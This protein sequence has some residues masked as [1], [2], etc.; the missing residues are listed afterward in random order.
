MVK[1]FLSGLLALLLVLAVFPMPEALALETSGVMVSNLEELKATQGTAAAVT[2]KTGANI[3]DTERTNYSFASLTIQEGASLNVESVYCT[4]NIFVYGT[5][6]TVRDIRCYGDFV[7]ANTGSLVIGRTL[8]MDNMNTSVCTLSGSVE[9]LHTDGFG[10]VDLWYRANDETDFSQMLDNAAKETNEEI[11]VW[12]R[13]NALELTKNAEIP[14]NTIVAFDDTSTTAG[15]T[16]DSGAE[17]VNHGTLMTGSLSGYSASLAVDGA[18]INEGNVN[19]GE[20][21]SLVINGTFHNKNVIRSDGNITINGVLTNDSYLDVCNLNESENGTLTLSNGGEYKGRGRIYTSYWVSEQKDYKTFITGFDWT[22]FNVNE[23]EDEGIHDVELTLKN[24]PTEPVDPP[25]PGPDD[26]SIKILELTPANGSKL[27]VLNTDALDLKIVFDHKIEK[28]DFDKGT[29]LAVYEYGTN[30]KV[31][32]VWQNQFNGEPCSDVSISY[33]D[34]RIM[35]IYTTANSVKLKPNTRYYVVIGSGFVT[36]EGTEDSIGVQKGDWVFTTA[37]ASFLSTTA[38]VTFENGYGRD[39]TTVQAEWKDEWFF[40]D[41]KTYNHTLAN[42]SLALCGASYASAAATKNALEAFGF[43][44]VKSYNYGRTLSE[45]DCD[46]VCY[47]FGS[48]EV[49]LNDGS[50]AYLI[51]V[52]IKGTSGNE[53]WYSNFDIGYD[54]RH[55]GFD[56]AAGRLFDDLKAYMATIHRENPSYKNTNKFLVT[57]HSRGAAVANLISARLSDSDYSTNRN[58]YGYTF[59]TPAVSKQASETGYENIF[60]IVS[61]E[62]FVPQLPLAKWGFKRYGVDLSLPSRSYYRSGQFSVV[63]DKMCNKFEQLTGESFKEYDGFFSGTCKVDAVISEVYR[64]APNIILYYTK[65]HDP[66]TRHGLIR[67]RTSDSFFYDFFAKMLVTDSGADKLQFISHA[68]GDFGLVVRFFTLNGTDIEFANIPITSNRAFSAHCPA[69]YYSWVNS[70]SAEELF[71]KDNN[72]TSM[73]F[74]RLAIACPVD[75]YVYGEDGTLL[76]SVVDEKVVKN[77]LAVSVEDGVKV[78]DLPSDQK[79]SVKTVASGD[80]TVAYTIEELEASP[81]GSIN[82]RTVKFNAIPIT[83]GDKLTGEIDANEYTDV[84]NYKLTKNEK[85]V[86]LADEDSYK[87]DTPVSPNPVQPSVSGGSSGQGTSSV[88]YAI[89]IPSITGG[90]VT[91]SRK[92]APKNTVVTLDVNPDQGFQLGVLNVTSGGKA[93]SLTKKSDSKYTFTMPAGKVQVEATFV[94]AEAS[95]TPWVNPFTD[96]SED[97]WCYNAI[98]FVSENKMMDGYGNGLFGVND[99]LSRA[100]LAQI[101]YNKEGKPAAVNNSIFTDVLPGQWYTSAIT[102]AETNG[103]VGGYGNGLF[104]PNDKITREQLAVMLWRYAKSPAAS[105]KEL[106]FTDI[107]MAGRYALD[108]LRWAAENGILNG[109]SDGRL[110]PKGLATRAQAAQMLKNYL[111]KMTENP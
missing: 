71:G 49:L 108:A 29:P 98:R 5:L 65:E 19:I 60:N 7:L 40:K 45:N 84:K 93:V 89:E 90:S 56:T 78:V 94:P 69:G 67:T 23:M 37:D 77:T 4:G 34:P 8:S 100:Q 16:I 42:T 53:E 64:L 81:G 2:I 104:G 31:Y 109:Y 48:K 106:H 86:I 55:K 10:G 85:D 91:A 9:Y 36:F 59:A 27:D 57:G 76:A 111:E 70:C 73:K 13:A 79:Y 61:G 51:A 83:E 28:L 44:Q 1:R 20:Q 96:V 88:S 66:L 105:D 107:D 87:P 38:D 22:L 47:S 26:S 24:Q 75:V 58:V 74:K 21:D 35:R 50:T 30:E 15:L 92:T 80:G 33:S 25:G 52:I 54:I 63:S 72:R 97:A 101:L 95:G 110:N 12:I 68:T 62:D 14:A 32:Q 39:M 3:V 41:S 82:H 103:I 43:E 102:W 99:N 6:E 11:H 17:L 46:Y 18:F